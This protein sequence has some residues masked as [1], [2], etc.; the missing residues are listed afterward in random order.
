MH[1]IFLIEEEEAYCLNI[2]MSTPLSHR[3]AAAAAHGFLPCNDLRFLLISSIAAAAAAGGALTLAAI[4]ATYCSTRG[5]FLTAVDSSLKILF[6]FSTLSMKLT[7]SVI[8]LGIF[9]MRQAIISAAAASACG[10]KPRPT[11]CLASTKALSV[12]LFGRCNV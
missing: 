7:K 8:G 3:A 9:N 6:T 12:Q 11:S 5:T 2:D 1:A 10:E 4:I